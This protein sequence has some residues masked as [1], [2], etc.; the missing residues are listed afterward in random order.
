MIEVIEIQNTKTEITPEITPQ[1][2]R[3]GLKVFKDFCITQRQQP[4]KCN[5]CEML[6]VCMTN[7][8]AKPDKWEV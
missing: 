1:L 5:Y 4:G 3:E 6:P 2:A 7:F 8:K